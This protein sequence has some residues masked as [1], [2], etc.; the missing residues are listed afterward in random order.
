[1]GVE[2]HT[3]RKKYLFLNSPQMIF[4]RNPAVFFKAGSTSLYICTSLNDNPNF[5]IT[6][7]PLELHKQSSVVIV[8]RT[9]N[10]DRTKYFWEVD[11]DGKRL[12]RIENKNPQYFRSVQVYNANPWNTPASGTVRGLYYENWESSELYLFLLI[13][14][15]RF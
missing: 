4:S 13:S 2:L 11:V 12:I 14:E 8:Q 15:S 3:N 7:Q 6:S 10:T 5:C 1:M 9:D